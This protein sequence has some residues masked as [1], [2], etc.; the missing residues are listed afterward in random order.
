[1]CFHTSNTKT[2]RELE[3][4]LNVR[5]EDEAIYEPFYHLN[6][7]D[8]GYLYG[9]LQEDDNY[10]EPMR[11]GLIEQPTDDPDYYD[12]RLINVEDLNKYNKEQSLKFRLNKKIETVFTYYKTAEPIRKRRCTIPITGFFENK[13]VNGVP[14][15]HYIK[16]S[17]EDLLMLAG[18]YN[19]YDSGFFTCQIL[20]APANEFMSNIHNTKKRMPVML[21][22][23]NWFE[24]LKDDLTDDE[25]K[26]ILFTDTSQELKAYPV[27][28]D[29]KNS[30][31]KSNR[32]DIINPYHYDELN[33]LF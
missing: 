17:D 14:Y 5:F 6:G 27:S 29:V 16:D 8:F 32:P 23:D 7:F 10:I 1:M 22:P 26:E 13:H 19:E 4:R 25:I 18:I 33:T 20:T 24:Y 15:P 2:A 9:I 31:I 12:T 28:G 3:D 30:N 11:W 21:H